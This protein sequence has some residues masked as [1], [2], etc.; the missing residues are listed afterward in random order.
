M[1]LNIQKEYFKFYDKPLLWKTQYHIRHLKGLIDRYVIMGD[2]ENAKDIYGVPTIKYKNGYDLK[3]FFVRNPIEDKKTV[4]LLCLAIFNKWHGYERLLKGL[5]N[6][7]K[8]GGDK[9][10]IIHFVG[11]GPEL[12]KYMKLSSYE[13]LESHVK[14]YGKMILEDVDPVFDV[15][16]VGICTLGN[17]KRG[18]LQSSELKLRQYLAKGIPIVTASQIDIFENKNF[19]YRLNYPNDDSEIDIR[20]ILNFCKSLYGIKSKK[21][22]TREIRNFA[23]KEIDISVKLKPIIRFIV[24]E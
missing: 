1:N 8:N 3:Q 6:Y 21:E 7:Y 23:D 10:I 4:D 22:V 2:V 20:E 17:Y 18:I 13:K 15:C 19:E 5:S 14:F 24:G 12:N 11:D 9:D 16:D